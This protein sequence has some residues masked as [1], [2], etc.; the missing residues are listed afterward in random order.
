MQ[1]EHAVLQIKSI[2][3][4]WRTIEFG[5]VT[6]GTN[7]KQ[8]GAP[9]IET[10]L[11]ASMNNSPHL[12]KHIPGL[13]RVWMATRIVGDHPARIAQLVSLMTGEKPRDVRAV[14]RSI[15]TLD[16]HLSKV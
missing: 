9:H 12:V 11:R 14:R 6:D 10:A 7:V 8:R 13:V 16:A 5:D 15:E 3:D 4:K 2:R 1:W